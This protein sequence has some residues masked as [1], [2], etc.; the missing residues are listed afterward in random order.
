M[1]LE[2]QTLPVYKYREDILKTIRDNQTVVLVG[3][4]GSGKTTQ[5]PQ[6]LHEVGYTK[7]GKIA[8]TQPRRVAAMSVATRVSQE[9]GCKLG[10]EVGYSIRFED[11]T[12]DKTVLK[13]MTDGML[14][15]EF[16]NE[17]DLKSYSVVMID[18]AH[19]RTLHTDIL[20]GLLKDLARARPDLKLVISSA[21]MD[22]EKFANY[23]DNA[24]II[25]VPGRRFPVDIY[26][27]KAPEADYI[28][29]A[30]LTALQI[31]LTQGKGDI[32]VFMTG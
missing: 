7:L 16:L 30:V 29:A 4:T 23:F 13:Y 1:K 5:I 12:S 3:E 32:L 19:E 28:E 25:N 31:H 22:A 26:Y 11:C 8:I 21:T 20:F 2:R 24:K 6:F 15:R 17:P 10:H 27:T 14:L 18:E 9:I